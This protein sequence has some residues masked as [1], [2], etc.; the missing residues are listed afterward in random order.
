MGHSISISIS[1]GAD[2]A[3]K[4]K[5]IKIIILVLKLYWHPRCSEVGLVRG[6]F[7]FRVLALWHFALAL[8]HFG[9]QNCRFY[10]NL[11]IP[12]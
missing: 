12:A 7:T 3:I 4:L 6:S 1:Y 2:R 10:K 11:A 5:K 8:R 9:T